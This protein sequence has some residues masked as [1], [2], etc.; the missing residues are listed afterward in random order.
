MTALRRLLED[1]GVRRIFAVFD[2][3]G[4]ETRIAGGAVRDA[5]AGRWPAEVDFAT[6][7]TPG[8]VMRRAAEAG[9]R[10]VPTGIAHGTVTVIVEGRPFEL[11]TL[12]RDVATDG[13]RAVV[14]FG[15]DWEEDARRRDFTING[16]F[17]D[18]RG[19]VHDFVGG[20]QDLKAGRVR[21]IGAPRTRIR[22]DYLRILRFFRFFAGYGAGAPD[23]EAL[24]AAIR[25][26]HGLDHLSRER[27]R[28]ELLKFLLAPRAP[29]VAALMAATGFLGAILGGVPRV[30][31]LRRLAQI[32]TALG[33]KPD[34]LLRLGALALFIPENAQ[35]LRER[36]RLSNEET[37]RLHAM[38]GQ[39]VPTPDRAA[40][41]RKA[42]LYRLGARAF[43]DRVL[44]AWADDADAATDDRSWRALLALPDLWPVPK[45]PI[46]AAD[47]MAEGVEKG[48]RLGRA[49]ALAENLWI[50]AGFPDAPEAVSAIAREAAAAA[51]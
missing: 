19:T 24:S 32:E 47:L 36:L 6:T 23:P 34:A 27:V 44:L 49:L 17:L 18:A 11:T 37:E 22:E 2:G 42:W 8:E 20:A 13:R 16:L 10:T 33:D 35:T 21:F 26:R 39:P 14:A 38:A 5:L 25:E 7:A 40:E 31:R 1:P 9:L 41:E 15:R 12:R 43:R 29:E 51:V 3:A 30:G 4:E 46:G 28:A 45:C 48:P 50:A